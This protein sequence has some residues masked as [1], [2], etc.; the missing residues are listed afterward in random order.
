MGTPIS[1]A[2]LYSLLY[3]KKRHKSTF[4]SRLYVVS[5]FP[6]IGV[7]FGKLPQKNLDNRW[8]IWYI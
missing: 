7:H 4:I 6:T 3:S 5:D 1:K 2:F 8:K